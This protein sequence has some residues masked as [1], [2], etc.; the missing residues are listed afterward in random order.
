MRMGYLFIFFFRC[1][2]MNYVHSSTSLLQHPS[3]I[4]SLIHPSIPSLIHLP[5]LPQKLNKSKICADA[6]LLDEHLLE[7]CLHFYSGVAHV[8][9]R[10]LTDGRSS[11]SSSNS[12][13]NSNSGTSEGPVSA[14]LSDTGSLLPLPPTL[15]ELFA[16]LPEWYLDDLAEFLLFVLQ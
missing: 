11:S 6:G 2:C 5:S 13:F 15:P 1:V 10:A 4:P 16:A 14:P 8:I 9:L 7:R 3:S 12:S